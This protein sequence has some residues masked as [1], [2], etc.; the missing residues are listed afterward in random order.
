MMRVCAVA[1]GLA[2]G[3]AG[4]H[5]LPQSYAQTGEAGTQITIQGT[6]PPICRFST[7]TGSGSNASFQDGTITIENLVETTNST[8]LRSSTDITYPRVMCNTRSELTIE[9]DRGAMVSQNTGLQA[10]PGSANFDDRVNYT[11]NGSWG[12]S[13]ISLDTASKKSVVVPSN[14]AN[15]ADLNLTIVTAEG[16]GPMLEGTYRDTLYITLRATP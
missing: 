4:M 3:F 9:S 10:A 14:G 16:V 7:P 1:L 8:T 6:V 13:A 12:G 11:V 2:L 5:G 15:E